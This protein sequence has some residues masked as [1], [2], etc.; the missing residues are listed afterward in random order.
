MEHADQLK[1]F[2]IFQLPALEHVGQLPPFHPGRHHADQWI[3]YCSEQ[4]YNIGMA[5]TLPD[6]DFPLHPCLYLLSINIRTVLKPNVFDG[7][8]LDVI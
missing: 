3:L 1:P 2:S 5:Q 8:L 7:D 4:W 6:D